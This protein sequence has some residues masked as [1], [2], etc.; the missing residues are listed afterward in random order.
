MSFTFSGAEVGATYKY[1]VTS[2]GGG[3]VTGSG[4]IETADQQIGDIDVS[5][6]GD[7]MLILSVTLIDLSGNSGDI[8]T[9][10]VSKNTAA[11]R[12]NIL[13]GRCQR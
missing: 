1:T 5:E 9:D 8:V 13:P 11:A 6:L 3:S 2:T 4:T 12:R 7:G 10:T